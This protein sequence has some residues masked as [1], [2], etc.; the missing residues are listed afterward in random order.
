MQDFVCLG[1]RAVPNAMN[2]NG[3]VLSCL[4]K[5]FHRN[6]P[7]PLAFQVFLLS[8]SMA[9]AESWEEGI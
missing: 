5:M 1:L 2:S 3:Q 8:F 6:Y 9:M 7:L 4:E